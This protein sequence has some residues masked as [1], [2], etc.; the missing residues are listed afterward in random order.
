ML[1]IAIVPV[2]AFDFF[3]EINHGFDVVKASF[4][5]R[6]LEF[7]EDANLVTGNAVQQN[8]L[9]ENTLIKV[10]SSTNAHAAVY[11]DQNYN[12]KACMTGI[13]IT[14]RTCSSDGSNA[15]I[16]LSSN[17]NAHVEKPTLANYPVSVCSS[18]LSCAYRTG[19]C[20]TG[21]E[22]VASISGDTNAHVSDCSP[23]YDTKLCCKASLC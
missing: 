22:C 3:S 12:F 4:Y 1:L 16:K 8:C 19:S 18:D 10:C 5:N 9:D 20:S 6:D 14:D 7:N 13:K 21:E 2:F 11:S 23:G 15:I 17:Y